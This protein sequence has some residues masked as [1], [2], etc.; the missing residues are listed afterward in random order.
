MQNKFEPIRIVEVIAAEVGQP[1]NDGS[2]GSALYSV[3]LRLSASAP[4][5]WAQLFVRAFDDPE[6]FTSMHRAGIA[7]VAG[8]KVWLRGT[9]LEEVASDHKRTLEAAARTANRAYLELLEMRAKAEAKAAT[10]AEQ[11]RKEIEEKA[12]SIKFD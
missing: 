1:R 4:G 3:P 6:S 9:T 2:C 12:R 8:D 10:E 5:E 7:T 11:R